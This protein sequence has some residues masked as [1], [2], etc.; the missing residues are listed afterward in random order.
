MFAPAAMDEH[1]QQQPKQRGPFGGLDLSS[2]ACKIFDGP[3]QHCHDSKYGYQLTEFMFA[4]DAMNKQKKQQQQQKASLL[5]L[6]LHEVQQLG[7]Q[8][9]DGLSQLSQLAVLSRCCQS[10]PPLLTPVNR[11]LQTR[12]HLASKHRSGLR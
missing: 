2:L 8:H 1:N 10:M 11:H 4:A 5:G 7:F 12:T 6:D 9:L 3:D